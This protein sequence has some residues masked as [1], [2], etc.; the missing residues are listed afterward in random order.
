VVKNTIEQR[1]H[2]VT[3]VLC[4]PLAKGGPATSS[5][6]R[7]QLLVI[8]SVSKKKLLVIMSLNNEPWT[9]SLCTL[10]DNVYYKECFFSITT[11]SK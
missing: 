11:T 10:V 2:F 7:K 4:T 5:H 9:K 6:C 1:K 3:G 8:M